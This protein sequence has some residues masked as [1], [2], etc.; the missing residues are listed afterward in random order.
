MEAALRE[1]QI[2]LTI[3]RPAWFIDNA[4]WDVASARDTGLIHS[5]LLPTDEAFP[6]VAAKDVGRMAAE[7][8]SGG[9]DRHTR[10]RAGGTMPRNAQRPCRSLRQR[11]WEAGARG[12]GAP[13]VLGCAVPLAGN[14][15]P[16]TPH[17]DA[18]RLQ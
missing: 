2:P 8:I 10:S 1:L 11:H 17:A 3:L 6:M 4:A 15:E 18:R 12:P 16:R 13:R 9:M 14:E 5:Y 7:L